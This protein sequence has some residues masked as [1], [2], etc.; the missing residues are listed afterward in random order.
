MAR[1]LGAPTVVSREMISFL[2]AVG[3]DLELLARGRALSSNEIVWPRE[4]KAFALDYLAE[5][6]RLGMGPLVDVGVVDRPIQIDVDT[7]ISRITERDSTS[8]WDVVNIVK[9]AAR[10]YIVDSAGSNPSQILAF[11]A[12][13]HHGAA[14]DIRVPHYAAFARVKYELEDLVEQRALQNEGPDIVYERLCLIAKRFSEIVDIIGG[15]EFIDGAQ[16]DIRQLTA[17]T[18]LTKFKTAVA[19]I[20]DAEERYLVVGEKCIVFVPERRKI[21]VVEGSYMPV[22]NIGARLSV[23]GGELTRLIK[24]AVEFEIADL[25]LHPLALLPGSGTDSVLE[26]PDDQ[27]LLHGASLQL[28]VQ[29]HEFGGIRAFPYL[30]ENNFHGLRLFLRQYSSMPWR[31]E[32]AVEERFDREAFGPRIEAVR[33]LR[34]EIDEVVVVSE[35]SKDNVPWI[36]SANMFAYRGVLN[37]AYELVEQDLRD[38]LSGSNPLGSIVL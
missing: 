3:A 33:G 25:P 18:L 29:R 2:H 34:S 20:M 12:L 37:A 5:L 13:G 28:Y 15:T 16:L 36:S 32:V 38:L 31:V 11:S 4:P 9:T 26:L 21:T 17:S 6:R 23:H 30:V 22:N 27:S 35:V 8:N 10:P 24:Q 19:S 7:E 1:Y 14:I